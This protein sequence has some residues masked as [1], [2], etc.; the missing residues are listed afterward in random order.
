M[1]D[2]IEVARLQSAFT[3]ASLLQRIVLFGGGY[4]I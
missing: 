1:R 2:A 4:Q 3:T